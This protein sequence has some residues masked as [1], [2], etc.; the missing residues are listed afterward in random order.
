MSYGIKFTS[1]ANL[2]KI[3]DSD[4]PESIKQTAS[5][6]LLAYKLHLA[7]EQFL[8]IQTLTE[9]AIAKNK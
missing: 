7:V 4:A 9:S 5:I 1:R 6:A 8:E 3:I 2:Q